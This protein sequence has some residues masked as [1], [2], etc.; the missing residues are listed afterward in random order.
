MVV[1]YRTIDEKTT[2]EV[3]YFL[4]SLPA[5]AELFAAA[6][7]AL[8][9][10]GRLG[11]LKTLCT[12]SWT[13]RFGKTP[14]GLNSSPGLMTILSSGFFILSLLPRLLPLN[15]YALALLIGGASRKGLEGRR[16]LWLRAFT[17]RSTGNGAKR[18]LHLQHPCFRFNA[19]G[20][21]CLILR[22]FV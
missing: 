9:S 16:N 10:Y 22:F 17:V 1:S 18:P 5:D 12:M 8:T 15:L 21:S 13:W 6:V 19:P 7:R 4:S 14:A 20:I 3:R 2:G 11:V